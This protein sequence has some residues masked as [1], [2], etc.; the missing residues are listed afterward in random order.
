MMRA[1][2]TWLLVLLASSAPPIREEAHV[3]QADAK[4]LSF[5]L[6]EGTEEAAAPR[7]ARP[8]AER[9]P[10]A[11]AEALLRRLP[12]LAAVPGAG[13]VLRESSLPPPRTGATVRDPFPPPAAADA[14][15]VEAGPLS[16]LRRAP[17]GE[18]P[19]A[20]SL[21]VTFSQPMVA[22]TSHDELAQG[23]LPVRLTPQPAGHW[24]W[25]GART[26][27][28]EPEGRFPMATSY[29]AEVPAGAAAAN[30]ARLAKAEAWTFTTPAP[31]L[32]ASFP[33]SG[34]V[35]PWCWPL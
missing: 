24:R 14:P 22:I 5:A 25:A 29:R 18:V 11:E 8:P 10:E 33:T 21:Q 2:A 17:E 34:P 3:E 31:K 30:G 19:L 23:P 27:L 1:T 13:F 6:G 32:V 26:L 7:L 9:L 4:G 35:R 12:A 20:P 16:V 15:H 28:F